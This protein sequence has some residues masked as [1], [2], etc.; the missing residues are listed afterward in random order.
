MIIAAV[1]SAARDLDGVLGALIGLR[2]N[3]GRIMKT[4][5]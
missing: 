5:R 1:S 4:H 2:F 3:N